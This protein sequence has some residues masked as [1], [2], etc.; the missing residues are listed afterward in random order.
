MKKNDILAGI[1][2]YPGYAII[3]DFSQGYTLFKACEILIN[4][5]KSKKENSEC[6]CNFK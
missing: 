5:P 2:R 6:L 3:T 4:F 1:M